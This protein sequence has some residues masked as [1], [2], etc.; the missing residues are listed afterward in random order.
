[1]SIKYQV[2]EIFTSLQG[3]GI[4]TGT[5]MTFIR[6]VGC[7][8]GKT[9]CHHCDTDFDR[10]YEW[11]GGGEFTI[12]E[13]LAKVHANHICLTG[14]EPLTQDLL[15]LIEATKQHIFHIETSGTVIPD[16]MSQMQWKPFQG[17][18]TK[19]IP[20]GIVQGQSQKFLDLPI[21][22]TVS[23]KPGF[24]QHMLS[25]AD[26]IKIIVPGLGSGDGWP[27]PEVAMA[28]A[29]MKP[30][31]LQPRNGK[32]DINKEN[33]ELCQELVLKHPE[34]RLSL[35]AHKMLVVR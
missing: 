7:S 16:W 12:E 24:H 29:R 6:F 18:V 19:R 22:L 34:L 23:P 11:K 28:Y 27:G 2:A 3:E 26:E 4:W 32:R 9:V 8:V 13:L 5:P 17:T 30:V 14:G 1:M 10:P 33:L 35:Q 20:L 25:L 15:P 21:W 31:F